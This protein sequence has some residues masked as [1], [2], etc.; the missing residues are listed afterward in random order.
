MKNKN[1]DHSTVT[2]PRWANRFL[3]WYC[4]PALLDEIEGDLHEVFFVRVK[5]QGLQKARL[6]YMKEVLLFF[7]PSSFEE[8]KPTVMPSLFRNYIKI[9]TRNLVKQK[10]YSIINIAG[11]AIALAITLLMLLW[12]QDE[13]KTDKFHANGDRLFL[14]KRTIPSEDGTVGIHHS[15][16]YPLL[17]AIQEELP[18]VEQYIPIGREEEM[19]LTSGEKTFRAKGTFANEGYFKFFSFPIRTGVVRGLEEGQEAIA[20]SESLAH[21]FFGDGW[22]TTAIGATINMNEVGDFIVSAVYNDFPANSSI[23]N[24][25]IYSLDNFVQRHD[26]MLDWRNSGMQA[27]LLLAEGTDANEVVQKIEQIYQEHLEGDLKEGCMV[28][29][30]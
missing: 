23:Q 3:K 11:L 21:K 16:P 12:V 22:L 24:D 19:T 9:A 30:F 13:W 20:I 17:E 18:E 6:L 10:G 25:F 4:A 26:W 14:L 28:Q 1:L 7:R 27:A 29:K 8:F 2:P 15:V 5:K